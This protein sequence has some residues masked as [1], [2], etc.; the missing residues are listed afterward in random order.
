MAD[1]LKASTERKKW[2]F[3]KLQNLKM[4]LM[5]IKLNN[6]DQTEKNWSS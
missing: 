2:I 3:S 1:R 5:L 6:A 4:F